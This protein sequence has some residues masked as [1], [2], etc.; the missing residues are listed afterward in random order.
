MSTRILTPDDA[1][2]F[3]ALRL[4]ALLDVPSAFGS[5]YEEERDRA[6]DVVAGRLAATG[7]KAVF[8]AFL[9]NRLVGVVGVRREPLRK[10][11]H[12]GVLWGMYIAPEHRGVGV[13]QSLLN[14]A[15]R[16]SQRISGLRQ[17]NLTVN[18][19]NVSALRLY[20]RF[21]FQ[22]FGREADSM[23]VDGQLYDEVH[24]VLPLSQRVVG[25]E[26]GS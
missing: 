20:R 1:S 17:I 19:A 21:G 24:M 18:A 12:K 6:V 26:S 15:L 9:E 3:Q 13:A 7:E 22:A 4:S 10:F 16:F 23:S 11:R 14:D 25:A 5:S 2:E 8:G